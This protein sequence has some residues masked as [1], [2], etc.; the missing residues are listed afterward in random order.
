MGTPLSGPTGGRARPGVPSRDRTGVGP[1]ELRERL[2]RALGARD[3]RTVPEEGAEARA[4]VTLLLRP[5]AGGADAVSAEEVEALFIQRADLAGDPWSGHMA[6]PGGRRAPEDAGLLGTALRELREETG[7]ELQRGDVLGRL[8]ELRPLS[9][10]LPA[11]AVSPFIA[12]TEAPSRVRPNR[13]LQDHVWVPIGRLR[14]PGHRTSLSLERDG[15]TL[16]FPAIEYRG[17]TIWGITF[18]IVKDFLWIL[19]RA[20]SPPRRRGGP[21]R[22]R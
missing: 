22:P 8:D 12:W 14:E 19:D 4:A 20:L 2:A 1:R 15:R 21:P 11:I 13:E 16:V 17:Y 9:R 18:E 10:R 6:L 7:I 5:A 3:P